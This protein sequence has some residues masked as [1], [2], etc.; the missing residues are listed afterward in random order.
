MWAGAGWGGEGTQGGH[1]SHLNHVT[2]PHHP[3]TRSPYMAHS[4]HLLR[5]GGSSCPTLPRCHRW[6]PLTQPSPRLRW[7]GS[8]PAVPCFSR[9]V[10]SASSIP[11]STRT[12]SCTASHPIPSHPIPSHPIP[13]HHIPSDPIPSHPIPSHHIRSHPI[14][15]HPIAITIPHSPPRL[16]PPNPC[17]P[18]PRRC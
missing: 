11:R 3:L 7:H 6:L 18:G 1:P 12:A 16:I 17:P 14:P 9:A 5:C 10:S 2:P 15:C 13:S 8:D 4:S